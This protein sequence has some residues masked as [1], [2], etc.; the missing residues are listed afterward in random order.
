MFLVF[1]IYSIVRQSFARDNRSL[2]AQ[3]RET[4]QRCRRVD[5]IRVSRCS[6]ASRDILLAILARNSDVAARRISLLLEFARNSRNSIARTAMLA[7]FRLCARE[8]TVT[9]VR[10]FM[11]GRSYRIYDVE[12][13]SLCRLHPRSPVFISMPRAGHFAKANLKNF[14]F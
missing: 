2:V 7:S 3:T 4:D 12:A 1:T 11:Y 10:N 5:R 6:F 9:G 13:S 8:I 14:W